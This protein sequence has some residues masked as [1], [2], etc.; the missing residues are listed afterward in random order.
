MDRNREASQAAQWEERRAFLFRAVCGVVWCVWCVWC[1]LY[2]HLTAEP[3]QPRHRELPARR[4][5]PLPLEHRARVPPCP[6][7]QLY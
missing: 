3:Q 7:Q 6:Q 4:L 5:P 1:V 2:L